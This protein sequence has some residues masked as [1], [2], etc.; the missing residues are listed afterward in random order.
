M[1][2]EMFSYMG[3]TFKSVLSPS[4]TNSALPVN[5]PKYY[6]RHSWFMEGHDWFLILFAQQ[7]KRQERLAYKINKEYLKSAPQCFSFR[8]MEMETLI[9]NLP[10]KLMMEKYPIEI[11]FRHAVRAGALLSHNDVMQQSSFQT[12]KIIA[13]KKTIT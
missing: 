1:A 5:I 11:C 4:P 12:L 3:F 6:H 10:Q 7:H 13:G 8:E 9:P 2:G